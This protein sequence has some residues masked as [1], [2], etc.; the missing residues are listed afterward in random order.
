M[1]KQD[2][3]KVPPSDT[4]A[5][6]PQNK[7]VEEWKNKYVRALADY[8]NLERRV[9]LER[10]ETKGRVVEEVMRSVLVFV[11]EVNMAQKHVKDPGL[12]IA[13]K[14]FDAILARFHIKKIEVL[15]KEFNPLEMECTEVVSGTKDNEV[16]EEVRA[17]YMIAETVL[18][19][20]QVK[21]SKKSN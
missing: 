5:E 4:P 16:V 20:A 8:Q 9:S 18:R 19:P 21:V 7:E 1:K 6:T 2:D 11:D 14:S 17:G 3:Q 13:L 12:E 15:H 10:L